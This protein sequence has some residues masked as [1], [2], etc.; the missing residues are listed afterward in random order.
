ML[1]EQTLVRILQLF[2]PRD[3][4]LFQGKIAYLDQV[5]N[6]RAGDSRAPYVQVL[7]GLWGGHKGEDAFIAY[8][9]AAQ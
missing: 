2:A 3:D 4:H 8:I 9:D 5:Q 7:K 6:P 1:L